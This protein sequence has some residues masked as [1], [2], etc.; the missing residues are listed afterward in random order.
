MLFYYD[1]HIGRE[2]KL[3]FLLGGTLYG[4]TL[5]IFLLTEEILPFAAG[6]RRDCLSCAVI[7]GEGS[8]TFEREF[9]DDSLPLTFIKV[10]NKTFTNV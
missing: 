7:S 5:P 6:V 10:N 3:P 8:L 4:G 1:L 2:Q 9:G